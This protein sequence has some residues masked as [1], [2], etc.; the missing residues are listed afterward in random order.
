LVLSYLNVVYD[1][2]PE[3]NMFPIKK[4][5]FS[6]REVPVPAQPEKILEQYY[7]KNWVVRQTSLHGRPDLYKKDKNN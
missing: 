6:G 3:E 4:V 2:F 5:P 7:S 1:K